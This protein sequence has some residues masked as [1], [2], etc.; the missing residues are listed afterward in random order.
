[1]LTSPWYQERLRTKQARDID[2]WQRNVR[3]LSEF[4]AL[5][6]HHEEAD[7]LGIPQRLEDAQIELERVKSP[8]YLRDLQ[9]SIGA[10]LISKGA[11]K[12]A[13]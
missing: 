5:P 9:G 7:R 2:L 6:G 1:M 11:T 8:A 4:L 13:P 10:D 3:S 12:T